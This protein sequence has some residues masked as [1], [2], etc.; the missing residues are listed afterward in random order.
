P[1]PSPIIT[2][3]VENL[4]KVG[5]VFIL[6][7]IVDYEL[8]RNFLL[9]GLLESIRRL[10]KLRRLMNYLPIKTRTMRK[11]AE[12]WAQAR[13]EGKPT[14]D[15]KEL[16]CDVILAAQ[17][18]EVGAIVATENIGH[19]SRFVEAKHWRDIIVI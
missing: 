7:E 19:L 6:S 16:D 15:L 4:A 14:A 11:A 10:D 13:R 9:E 3:W 17:A 1:R 12:L 5:A 8:R 2:A 18:I